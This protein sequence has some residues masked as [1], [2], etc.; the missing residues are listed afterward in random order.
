MTDDSLDAAAA[1]PQ[2][3]AARAAATSAASN[4]TT[5]A[6]AMRRRLWADWLFKKV[7]TL[8]GVSVLV[9]ITLIFFYLAS[10]ALPLFRPAA[11]DDWKT[12]AVPGGVAQQTG[13]LTA[14]EQAEIGARITRQGDVEFFDLRN[15]QS[16]GEVRIPIP[17]DVRMTAFAAADPQTGVFG[18]GLSDGR[19]V[20]AQTHYAVSFDANNKRR[21]APAV[22]YPLGQEPLDIGLQ[23]RAVRKL[24]LQLDKDG[25][26]TFAALSEDGRIHI[27][28]KT[29]KT[30]LITGDKT[31][32]SVT[33]V[34]DGV[35]RDVFKLIV[36]V[37]QR[38]LY[39]AHDARYITHVD[40]NDK[41]APKL[42]EKV[43]VAAADDE[44][45][46]LEVLSGGFSLIVGS[47]SGKLDQWFP[48]RNL[49]NRFILT[50]IRSFKPMDGAVTALAPEVFRKGFAAGDSQ[51]HAAL[52]YATSD[53]LLWRDH[54]G[55]GP[56]Q[57]LGLSPRANALLVQ[58]G[59]GQLHTARV[60]N[61]YPEVSFSALWQKVWYESYE[62][63]DYIWQS[64]AATNDFEP[65]FSLA[66]LTL[67][68]LKAA[69][70]AMLLA[71]PLA[72][73]A[74][75]YS[76][77]FMSP[78]TRRIAKPS[79][80]LMEALPTV[81]LGFLAG[82]WLAPLVENNLPATLLSF[83]FIP[84]FV[85]IAAFV[86]HLLPEG[87][88][89]RVPAGWEAMLLLGVVMFAIWLAFQLGHP[90]EAQ[91]FGGDMPHWLGKELGIHYEQRN[92]LV[93]GIAMGFAVTPTIF[94]IAEDAI[95]S[96]P[97]HL[98]TGSLAL[99]ATPW[100][101]LK[102]VVLPTAS[103]GIFSAVMIGMGRAV[104]ET[105]IVLM[106]TGNTAVMNLSLFTGFRTLAAN[107]GVE[108]PEAAVGTTHFRLLF[109]AALVLFA[110]TFVVNTVAELVRQRLRQKYS[111]I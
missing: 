29:A 96:V 84:L 82:L 16:R 42:A 95:F 69:F 111:V 8:G 46:A 70:Y 97:R 66:P 80:E 77:Y 53:R 78:R 105:M 104:G 45:S 59:N 56:I 31:W 41:A 100:Q 26:A 81:I 14:E 48:V 13:M 108:M 7:M 21:I 75:I 12:R 68:T 99:G 51:G 57:A 37:R 55:P 4:L 101:T 20:V 19:V 74:A 61:E 39:I 62:K 43:Q 18:Y 35:W 25:N 90:I 9:A 33:S 6:G 22:E 24:A 91:F 1:L 58:T 47:Q 103:P 10:V 27:A 32:D 92:S 5:I 93:V 87:L 63:P 30:N 38:E 64:A 17:A 73:L 106:A 76:A 79:L 15:G 110:F 54:V 98:T 107:I 2:Q 86:W 3:P 28:A 60:E 49:D 36:E 65:K 71:T 83:V 94:S 23:G 44:I 11:V 88:R 52:Y 85:L 40:L 102:N 50:H 109:V 67:G 34:V 89:N 72:I